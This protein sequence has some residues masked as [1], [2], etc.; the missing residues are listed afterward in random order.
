MIVVF[1]SQEFDLS[2]LKPDATIQQAIRH[3]YILMSDPKIRLKSLGI[4]VAGRLVTD[5]STTLSAIDTSV[6]VYAILTS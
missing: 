3:L 2:F 4:V 6:P 1:R 5:T